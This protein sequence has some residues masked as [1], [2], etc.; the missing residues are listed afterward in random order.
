MPTLIPRDE[1]LRRIEAEC[2]APA[3]LMCALVRGEAGPVYAIA[4]DA[5]TLVMLPR[6]VRRWGQ[7]MVIPKPHVTRFE[8]VEPDLWA[9]TSRFAH[10]AARMIERVL[11]PR[12]CYVASIGSSAGELLQTSRHLHVHVIPVHAADDRPS[13]V[14][15]WR[16]GAY[17]GSP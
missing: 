11:R 9:R 4:E 15:S 17:V 14:F 5:T 10:Q 7:V 16:E 12:R 8:E 2:G 3:C 1:A 6:Y 13:E